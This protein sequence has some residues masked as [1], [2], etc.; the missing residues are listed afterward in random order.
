MKA[1]N[2]KWLFCGRRISAVC[3]RVIKM[4]ALVNAKTGLT[5]SFVNYWLDLLRLRSPFESM[6]T[7]STGGRCYQDFLGFFWD[8][9]GC[10]SASCRDPQ[11]GWMKL[12]CI[13]NR[14][15][16]KRVLKLLVKWI[17]EGRKVWP[18]LTFRPE[19][20]PAVRD[21]PTGPPDPHPPH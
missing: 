9:L 10:L 15:P 7:C 8:V 6:W 17:C 13:E 18:D 11:C 5:F 3:V 19:S 2:V 16:W 20:M 1:K 21:A 4:A 14:Q 12:F